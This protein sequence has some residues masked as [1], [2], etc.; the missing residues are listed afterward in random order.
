MTRT[1]ITGG[2]GFIGGH[3]A[4]ALTAQGQSVT[5]LDDFSSGTRANLAKGARL[6]EGSVTDPAAV[7]DAMQ[8]CDQIYHF[9]AL[10]SVPAC[11]D[12]WL[13][14]H[15]INIG[16]TINV[17]EAA[18]SMGGLPVVYA[19][20]AAI[21]G[22]LGAVPCSEGALPC[23]KSPY[24][25]DKLSCEHHARAFWVN[26]RVP[27][28]GLRFFNIYGPGQSLS[29]PYAG[30]IARFAD[31]A[32][33]GIPHTIFGEGQ[34][35]RDFVYVTDLVTVLQTLMTNIQANSR[36]EVSNVCT[37]TPTSLLDLIGMI[38]RLIAGSGQDIIFKDTRAGDIQYSRGDDTHLKSL[39]GDT[40]WTPMLSGLRKTIAKT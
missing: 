10:V 20:S 4:R 14:G 40:H 34:Q 17:F 35:I 23:P 26:G 13:E 18:K 8:D 3:L 7:R 28:I 2:A 36:A 11:I 21:Y 22:D 38:D 37:N 30:V 29:S 31:N 12:N 32:A 27:S 19:S 16:G 1:L 24:G 9:A 15:H 33:N 6:V 5:I 25:A 39:I